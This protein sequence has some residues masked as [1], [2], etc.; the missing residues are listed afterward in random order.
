MTRRQ[1]TLL[2]ACADRN[3]FAPWFKNSAT[4]GAWFRIRR[5]VVRAAAERRATRDIQAMHRPQRAA[6]LASKRGVVG[7]RPPRR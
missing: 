3:L 4:W 5:Y 7:L 6:N 2:D 1:P